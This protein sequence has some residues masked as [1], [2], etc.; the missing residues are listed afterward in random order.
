MVWEKY[1]I[2][3][4]LSSNWHQSHQIAST[5]RI[6]FSTGAST[7]TFE[8]IAAVDISW[9]FPG[10]WLKIP[11]L[12]L[13]CQEA[14]TASRLT[15]VFSGAILVFRECNCYLMLFGY[16]VYFC[17]FQKKKFF[18]EVVSMSWRPSQ[19]SSKRKWKLLT[20]S[21]ESPAI[22]MEVWK[23]SVPFKL[24]I[25]GFQGVRFRE[26]VCCGIRWSLNFVWELRDI[27]LCS[28][29]LITRSSGP[30]LPTSWDDYI[31]RACEE[32]WS[33]TKD[34]AHKRLR[35]S[36]LRRFKIHHFFWG[37]T[38]VVFFSV[39]FSLQFWAKLL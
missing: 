9:G 12:K 25:F 32:D 5:F 15:T 6:I 35:T 22:K 7:S 31:G 23:I 34:D 14:K 30:S 13:T 1:F 28:S 33:N 18:S 26:G 21:S 3:P 20:G 8:K 16:L 2:F 36:Q 10:W 38:S 29:V 24:V 11:S 27:V 37:Q 4:S 17:K 19:S 39:V